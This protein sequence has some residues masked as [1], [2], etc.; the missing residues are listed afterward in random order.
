M[1]AQMGKHNTGFKKSFM[2]NDNLAESC[3]VSRSE[4]KRRIFQAA[5][6]VWCELQ[7]TQCYQ[8]IMPWG[9]DSGS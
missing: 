4:Q 9:I 7:T 8:M 5:R 2:K 3:K 1:E 6:T